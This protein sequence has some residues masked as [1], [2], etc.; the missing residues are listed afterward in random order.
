MAKAKGLPQDFTFADWYDEAA[1]LGMSDLFMITDEDSRPL[2]GGGRRAMIEEAKAICSTCTVRE[3]C[4]EL[5]MEI[6]D[7]G[8]WGGLSQSQLRKM[9]KEQRDNGT[10]T[11]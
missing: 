9:K 2:R 3:P 4:A 11:S 6:G 8:V 5:G 10:T 1:C 7:Y